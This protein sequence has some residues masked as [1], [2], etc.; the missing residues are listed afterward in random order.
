MEIIMGIV[1][2]ILHI[3]T[4]LGEIIQTYGTLSYLILFLIIFAETGFV[5]TPF[6][7]GDSLLFA[8][9]AF[10]AIGSFNIMLLLGLLWV[11]AFLGDTT[12]Y[13]IGHFFGQ[14]IIDNPK[15]PFINQEHIDKTQAFYKKHG[16]KTI[17][18]ARFVPI[19]RTFAPFVAG[20]GKMS[21]G[22]FLS[23]NATG[24]F[25]WVF[26][27]TLLGYF[28]GNIPAVKEN[29]T[30]AV[31]AIILLS[32]IPIVMEFVKHRL[33]KAATQKKQ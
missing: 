33:N 12:N 11:A 16:G 6:L 17:F 23:Y 26:G 10:A 19:V 7:P 25:V 13:W 21:Y 28:F 32:V 5:F 27:F 22:K 29:F 9:G 8:S 3:D 1:D 14:K 31:F 30:L 4:H 20:V 15:I 18:L 2:F 24:G